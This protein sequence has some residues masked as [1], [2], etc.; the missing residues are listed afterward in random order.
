MRPPRCGQADA[1]NTVVAIE[2]IFDASPKLRGRLPYPSL[3]RSDRNT[4]L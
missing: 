1:R 4:I 3:G 2:D